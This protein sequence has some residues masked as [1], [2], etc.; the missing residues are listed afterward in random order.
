ML[1][2]VMGTKAAKCHP[3]TTRTTCAGTIVATCQHVP[4]CLVHLQL[5][6]D[7]H[8]LRRCHAYNPRLREPRS[9]KS[10]TNSVALCRLRAPKTHRMQRSLSTGPRRLCRAYAPNVQNLLRNHSLQAP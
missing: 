1:V 7:L 10:F 5:D 9:P 3:I 2:S 4:Q 6:T 8:D